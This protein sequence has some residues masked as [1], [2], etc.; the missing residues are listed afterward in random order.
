MTCAL[1]T[2]SGLSNTGRLTTQVAMTLLSRHASAIV[3]AQAHKGE[4]AIADAVDN[5]DK[6]IVIE[7]CSDHC[8]LKKLDTM[9]ITADLHIV[10]TELGVEKDGLAD[11]KWSD[12]EKVLAAFNQKITGV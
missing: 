12:V 7:G 1:V 9:G 3:W 4:H 2:C 6:I 5:A 10:A 8:A 11:V